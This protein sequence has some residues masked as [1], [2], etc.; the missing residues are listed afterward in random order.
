LEGGGAF[1]NKFLKW[2][3]VPSAQD[4]LPRQ[5]ESLSLPAAKMLA[6]SGLTYRELDQ[7]KRYALRNYLKNTLPAKDF[8]KADFLD[9]DIKRWVSEALQNDHV[10][11]LRRFGRDDLLPLWGYLVPSQGSRAASANGDD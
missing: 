8:G 11:L 10:E 1:L 6:A 2:L 5:N 7:E 9:E 4:E 3:D